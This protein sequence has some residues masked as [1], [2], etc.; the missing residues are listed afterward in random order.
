MTTQATAASGSVAQPSAPFNPDQEVLAARGNPS[1][2]AV[3]WAAFDAAYVMSLVPLQP[4]VEMNFG[5]RHHCP[6]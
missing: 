3:S 1:S 2:A 4:Q 5:S 6:F